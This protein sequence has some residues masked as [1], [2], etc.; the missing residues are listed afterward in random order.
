[1]NRT[2]ST[3]PDLVA[4]ALWDLDPRVVNAQ[5]PLHS[6]LVSLALL[7]AEKPLADE[8]LY[9]AVGE[10]L[11]IE[12][13]ISTDDLAAAITLNLELHLLERDSDGRLDLSDL[14]RAQ[15]RDAAERLELE[16]RAFHHHMIEAVE[17]KGPEL[18]SEERTRLYELLEERVQELL[19]AQSSTV[20]AAWTSGGQGFDAGF[21]DLN[22]REHL[23]EVANAMAPGGAASNK[24]R[25]VTI[26]L[27]L[28]DGLRTLPPAAGAYLAAL[29]QRT[30]AFALLQ[31]DPTVRRVKA[32]LA[33]QRVA[34]LDAN[35]VMAAMFVADTEHD[36][37][38][39]A[40]DIT[41]SLGAELRVTE[42]TL[43]E[44]AARIEAASRFMS[45]YRGNPEL[46]AAVDDVIVRS[47]H[48]ATRDAPGLQ[49]GAYIGGFHPPGPWLD[50][51]GIII[52]RAENGHGAE[53]DPRLDDVRAAV[54][55][56]RRYA[57]AV[58]IQT[59]AL[60]LLHITQRR[61]VVT[62]DEMGNRV[63]LVTLDRSLAR[64][65]RALVEDA[66]LPAGASRLVRTWVDLLSPCLPPDEA[67]LSGY[68]THLVQ[69]QMSLLA[70][71]P[72]FVNKE[73]LL[74]LTESRFDIS[75]VLGASPERGRQ[76]LTRLQEDAELQAL[77]GNAQPEDDVWNQQLE[78]A[79]RRALE[80]IERSPEYLVEIEEERRAR[81]VAERRAHEELRVRRQVARELASV[82]GE[83]DEARRQRDELAAELEAERKKPWWRQLFRSG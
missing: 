81:W 68:V 57:S 1:V 64:A 79:V 24:L 63:W 66:I 76:I 44:L 15:L 49:W 22:A 10:L 48:R 71:D 7:E 40:L 11:P 32:Q 9:A 72:M 28:E 75:D 16:R 61:R 45:R 58:V 23:T 52:E 5:R 39:Q 36:L 4:F 67:R 43:Q 78:A 17:A 82:R 77:L 65:E 34:Y 46:R 74:T 21:Q 3:I 30:V 59:D 29:Y 13:T 18:S 38:V 83:A 51:Q 2:I 60:N 26:A 50:E 6:F 20:A 62:A 27:G 54:G 8:E 25:R 31:Q 41:R 33:G 55:R 80:E 12:A 70:E 53:N 69:S 73:F 56:M 42:F 35:V 14:R 19:Q 37:A 47:Y